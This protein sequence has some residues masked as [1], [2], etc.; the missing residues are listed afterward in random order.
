MQHVFEVVYEL[1][2]TVGEAVG[3][4]LDVEHY[5]HLHKVYAPRYEALWQDG[6][7]VAVVQTWRAGPVRF[8]SSCTTEY[9][10]PACF[11]NYD[12]KPVPAWM[13]SIHHLIK[14]RTELRYYPTDDQKRTVSH[15]TVKLDLPW[16]MW[17]LRK[18][19]EARLT[20]LK[21]EKDQEDVDMIARSQRI[22]GRGNISHY[23]R[24]DVFMLH[25]DAFVAH[26]GPSAMPKDRIA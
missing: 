20:R 18:M 14:T 26:F 24:K 17:P 5:M 16:I 9:Q 21:I 12:L 19:I 8:G 7:K 4:Y 11:L 2:C 15:L 3:A 1:D 13:P 25:K 6:T 10:P 22:F 23:F